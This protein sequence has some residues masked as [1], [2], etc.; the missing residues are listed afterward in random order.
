[1]NAEIIAVGTELL[2]GDTQDTNS[3]WIG[4]KLPE[5]GVELKHVTIVGDDLQRL[6]STVSLA[7]ERSGLIII[8]GGL[9]PT[10]DDLTREAIANMLEEE[11]T[12]DP[13]LAKWLEDRFARRN[14]NPMPIQ[15]L[16]QAGVIP[17]AKPIRN[18][19]GTA[20]SW[21]VEKDNRILVTLPGPPRELS[22]MWNTE[23]AI[24]LKDKLP[25]Q[26]IL[27]KTF[28]TIG[29][30]EAA[31]DEAVRDV[32]EIEEL[33]FG[34]YAKQDGIYVRAIAK[35]PTEK[36]ASKIL[37]K[38]ESII[39]QSLKD[40]IWGTNED[41]PPEKVGELLVQQKLTLAVLESCT[42]GLLGAALTEIP[43]SSVYF[44]GGAITYTNDVKIATGIPSE[45]IDNFGAVSEEVAKEMAVVACKR[46]EAD[47]GI[48]I[49]G[50][51]GPGDHEGVKA[52]T[53]FIGV[54]TPNSVTVSKHEFPSRRPLVRN[55]AVTSALLQ[56]I[57][58]LGTDGK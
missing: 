33:D 28:K 51:A 44:M 49:T 8:M 58:A 40:Y 11:L 30:S 46:F 37:E 42:G 1:M 36:E 22:T 13:D 43:G 31:V 52:G 34:V 39:R 23:I 54:S 26:K 12:T 24:R 21:W 19:M 9:G 17:S 7:W 16:R 48:G 4:Q 47:C 41:Y 15:N 3:S 56:L 29:L 6:T 27:S 5:F 18:S 45:L 50:I 2:M 14:I 53:V 20:P 10:L 55:R 57:R 25:G 32:Y 38:A 35:A